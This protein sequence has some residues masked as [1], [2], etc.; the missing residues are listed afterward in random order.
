MLLYYLQN[1]VIEVKNVAKP[2][3]TWKKSKKGAQDAH[4]ALGATHAHE[5]GR[6][7]YFLGGEETSPGSGS[8]I[9]DDNI[10]YVSG[11]KKETW[12]ALQHYEQ[13]H[14]STMD[15]HLAML[16]DIDQY[17]LEYED[18]FGV[19]TDKNDNNCSAYFAVH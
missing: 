7:V 14:T 11:G 17:N 15:E 3:K 16:C 2:A 6:E 1:G 12:S 18:V 5:D 19:E 9:A 10:E 8:V 13:W 4:V